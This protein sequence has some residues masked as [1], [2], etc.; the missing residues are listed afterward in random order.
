MRGRGWLLHLSCL[1]LGRN[2]VLFDIGGGMTIEGAL[3][4]WMIKWA[5]MRRHEADQ[6][7]Q[8][9]LQLLKAGDVVFDVGANHGIWSMLAANRGAR[10]HAFE[11]VPELVERLRR[12]A[13]R[14]DAVGMVINQVAVGAQNGSLP[15]FAVREGNT[16]ASS[17]VRRGAADVEIRVPV[18]TLDG[19]V[20]SQHIGHVDLIK[21]DVEGAE[22]LVLE[23]ARGLLSSE[24]APVVF[25]EMNDELSARFGVT[26]RE[27]KQFLVDRGYGIYRWRDSAFSAVAVEEPHDEDLFALKMPKP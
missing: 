9:S 6:P 22:L 14:N 11:P 3:T 10:V 12:H 1:L 17:F 2:D 19:Y 24:R 25:F 16:G 18:M 23:G 15:F 4:D 27:V 26:A 5:F 20:E 21:I 8:R 7:F 13:Q